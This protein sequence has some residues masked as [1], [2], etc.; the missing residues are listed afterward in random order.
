[1]GA[2]FTVYRPASPSLPYLAVVLH[3]DETVQAVPFA[4]EEQA[5]RFIDEIAGGVR[6]LKSKDDPSA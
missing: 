5:Q 6:K 1:M 4:T 2:R 3:D